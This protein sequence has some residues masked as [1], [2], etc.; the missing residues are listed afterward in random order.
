MRQLSFIVVRELPLLVYKRIQTPQEISI[1]VFFDRTEVKDRTQIK[2]SYSKESL[3]QLKSCLVLQ[4][5]LS[6][7][8]ITH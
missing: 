3:L 8:I 4:R 7:L 5:E 1:T 6:N 2:P